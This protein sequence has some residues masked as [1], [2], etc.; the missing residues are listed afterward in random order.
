MNYDIDFIGAAFHG[1][2]WGESNGMPL[3]LPDTSKIM[4]AH[5]LSTEGIEIHTAAESKTYRYNEIEPVSLNV[6]LLDKLGFTLNSDKGCH[7]DNEQ[8]DVYSNKID[9]AK[10]GDKF[11]LWNECEDYWYSY[12]GVEVLYLH[13]LQRLYFS[14]TGNKLL[15]A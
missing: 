9:I 12:R 10:S 13:Q 3:R 15:H 4:Y 2:Y 14:L 5:F 7:N 6:T 11:Y 8:F 1:I